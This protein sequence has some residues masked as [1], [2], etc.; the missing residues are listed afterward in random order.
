MDDNNNHIHCRPRPPEEI[1]GEA[2]N[3]MGQLQYDILT[4]D[5]EHFATMCRYGKAL[6]KQVHIFSLILFEYKNDP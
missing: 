1:K 4:N 3:R 5:C 6:C 2:L